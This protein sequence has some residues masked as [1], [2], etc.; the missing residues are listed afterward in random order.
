[1]VMP[2][3]RLM[4]CAKFNPEDKNVS[5]R[6]DLPDW[7]RG[8]AGAVRWTIWTTAEAG[9]GVCANR[10]RTTGESLAKAGAKVRGDAACA[11]A[12]LLAFLEFFVP[13]HL[14]GFQLS[15]VRQLRV[16]GKSGQLDDPF[17]HVREAH[18]QRVHARMFF[19]ELDADFL[20]VV[21]I[22]RLR[23]SVPLLDANVSAPPGCGSRKAAAHREFL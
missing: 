3:G 16:A 15:F 20:G 22:K 5:R 17:V 23:H 1:M 19:G 6:R 13:G 18:G 10:V 14:N 8:M 4:Q 11:E 12:A 9:V 7:M 21:P 2:P